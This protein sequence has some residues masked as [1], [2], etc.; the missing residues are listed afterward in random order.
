MILSD[1]LANGT[2]KRGIT[3]N[4]TKLNNILFDDATGEAICLIDL[5]TVMPG[6]V[7]FDTGDLIRTAANTACEDEQDLS[8]VHF[9]C[10]IFKALIGGYLST[11][12]GCLTAYEKSI[13]AESGR[14]L[15]QIMAVRF[16][17]DYLNGDIYYKTTRP[18]HNLD[19]VRTQ[20]A[21]IKS[22]DS[23]WEQLQRI[24]ECNRDCWAK[25]IFF[26]KLLLIAGFTAP[27]R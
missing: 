12:G 17:T 4:D 14:I 5:D 1:G 6:T 25:Y 20:I 2:L 3:H 18:T 15:T 21:L 10:N 13:I 19:R 7:L 22:M 9:D 16:L 26:N 8:K 11:A 27:V 24:V 23:Q